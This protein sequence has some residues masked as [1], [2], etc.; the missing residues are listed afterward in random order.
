MGMTTTEVILL[1]A[2]IAIT[3]SAIIAI[4]GWVDD[5]FRLFALSSAEVVA[6]DLAGIVS[7]SGASP[8]QITIRY[9]VE[10]KGISYNVELKD[11]MIT[12]VRLEKNKKPSDPAK[13]TYAVD[14]L[15]KDIED[16][17]SFVIEK[18]DGKYYFEAVE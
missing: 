10:F 1:I 8:D 4:P 6:R 11:R 7:I 13:I 3:L 18:K 9:D 16:A 17:K 15:S 2:M 14:S 12:V 5:A